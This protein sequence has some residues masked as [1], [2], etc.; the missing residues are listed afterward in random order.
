[1]SLFSSKEQEVQKLLEKYHLNSLPNDDMETVVQIANDLAGNGLITFGTRL[2]G[3]PEDVAKMTYLSALVRQNWIM[4]NQL[5]RI[6]K[7]LENREK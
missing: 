2:S 6:E 3:K 4:I 7:L 5:S 1:M